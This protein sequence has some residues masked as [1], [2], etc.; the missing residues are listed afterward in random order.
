MVGY[1]RQKRGAPGG[2][3]SHGRDPRAC[4][5]GM[6]RGLYVLKRVAIEHWRLEGVGDSR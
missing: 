2:E 1:D 6:G 5:G 4:G 3:P